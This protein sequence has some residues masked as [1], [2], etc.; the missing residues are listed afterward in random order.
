MSPTT[1]TQ[2]N[3]P[4]TAVVASQLLQ[5]TFVAGLSAGSQSREG[6]DTVVDHDTSRSSVEDAALR[7]RACRGTRNS[8]PRKVTFQSRRERRLRR[9]T[10]NLE[11][12]PAISL[13]STQGAPVSSSPELSLSSNE[14]K[15]LRDTQ[16]LVVVIS[17]LL[18]LIALVLLFVLAQRRCKSRKK[19]GGV[20]DLQLPTKVE[21]K[22]E[23]A[24][25]HGRVFGSSDVLDAEGSG[26]PGPRRQPCA[27]N[28]DPTL[29]HTA[30]ERPPT[31]PPCTARFPSYN[32][33]HKKQGPIT[34]QDR[35]D[36]NPQC[37]D[38][39][40]PVVQTRFVSEAPKT[41]SPY[42]VDIYTIFGPE[43]PRRSILE[44]ET[45][46]A[47]TP[48]YSTNDPSAPLST[49]PTIDSSIL[50][51]P[52]SQIVLADTFIPSTDDTIER[53]GS[54][55]NG[56]FAIIGLGVVAGALLVIVALLSCLLYARRRAEQ[57]A[58]EDPPERVT[59]SIQ[60]TELEVVAPHTNEGARKP[61]EMF[62]YC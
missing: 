39:A 29:H 16:V 52:T 58:V 53:S 22:E 17:V 6:L 9:P 18:G 32:R 38:D 57:V 27:G 50:F 31:A 1:A 8:Q 43:N 30:V 60:G 36:T 47:T 4:S 33:V 7:K 44:L 40:F 37:A 28:G 41:S 12:V 23:Q 13:G 25:R 59:S 26:N 5:F 10:R 42:N 11:P 49:K 15:P 48:S 19:P 21:S 20:E 14:S 54:N 46:A 62:R 34:Q 35:R 45:T 51:V 3:S 56:F 2:A 24:K 61:G 55:V